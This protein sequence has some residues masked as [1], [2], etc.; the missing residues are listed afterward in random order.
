MSAVS[1]LAY[2]GVLGEDLAEWK[3]FASDVFGMQVSEDSTDEVLH[4]RLDERARRI[5]VA[6]GKPGIDYLG[7]EVATRADLDELAARLAAAGFPAKD[8]PDLAKVR[9][10]R[11]LVR[12][13]DPTG[14]PVELVVGPL[15]AT[16]VFASPRGVRFKTGEQGLGHVFLGV[17]DEEES[18]HFYVDLLG[19][20]LSDTIDFQ[21]AEGT[22]LHCNS[23]HHTVAY[24]KFPG[25]PGLGHFMVEV[26][27]LDAVGRAYDVVHDRDIPVVMTL[28]M[29]TNDLM[30]SFY[31]ATPSGF[32]LEYGTNG[33]SIDDDVWTV[34]HYDSAD[35]WGHK[36]GAGAPTGV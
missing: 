10:V 15:T 6:V 9:R 26:D 21:I 28:G 23:R 13:E 29:H 31:V 11:R 18:W 2:I 32:H 12:T 22:F 19:F 20:R 5:S 3:A 16:S 17:N 35:F 1:N 4:L 33:R 27:T 25:P 36:W 14:N 8:D 24:A 7:F 30:V 34:G